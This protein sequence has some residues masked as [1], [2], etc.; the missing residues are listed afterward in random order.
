MARAAVVALVI[1]LIGATAYADP[2]PGS[3][4]QER[5]DYF[6]GQLIDGVAKR[7]ERDRACR[8][9]APESGLVASAPSAAFLSSFAPLRRAA[10]PD[11][12][13]TFPSP[14]PR[15]S[16]PV[17]SGYAR[18]LDASTQV[19]PL[20][21]VRRAARAP[22]AASRSSAQASGAPRRSGPASSGTT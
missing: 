22:S 20:H 12:N 10:R 2:P 15:W 16:L 18:V 11:E 5:R 8:F 4:R 13:V 17:Y 14:S 1:S 7:V 19:F 9:R 21:D 6:A 3:S